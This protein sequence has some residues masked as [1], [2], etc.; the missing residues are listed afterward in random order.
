[1]NLLL[2]A[3]GPRDEASL[4]SLVETIL[5][6]KFQYQFESWKSIRFHQKGVG[7]RYH[8]KLRYSVGQA[9]S[10]GLNG[11]VAVVDRDKDHDGDRDR[12]L[13]AARD[14]DR[15]QGI[16]FPTALGIAQPH[17]DVWLLDDEVAVRIGLGLATNADVVNVRKTDDPKA[18]LN[19]LIRGNPSAQLL[20]ALRSIATNVNPN[21]C[22]H[23]KETGFQDFAD[24]CRSE[25]TPISD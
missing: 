20:E 4:P 2:V 1:M 9:R 11:L 21:R 23:A 8:K 12:D 14:A 5:G 6:R 10:R 7:G 24:D 22:V 13:H 25:L 3:D 19:G 17:V 18:E 15:Q 16:F